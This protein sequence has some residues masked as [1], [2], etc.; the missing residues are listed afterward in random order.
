VPVVVSPMGRNE[1]VLRT[2][3]FGVG[4]STA[5]DWVTALAQTLGSPQ[6]AGAM[7]KNGCEAV[8]QN[9]S[10]S[11]LVPRLAGERRRVAGYGLLKGPCEELGPWER[12]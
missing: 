3:T 2:G 10:I 12:P 4:A 8:R 5:A 11:G 9:F 7:G 1:A 6:L